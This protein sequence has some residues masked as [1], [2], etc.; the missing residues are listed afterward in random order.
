MKKTL[1]RSTPV[2]NSKTSYSKRTSVSADFSQTLQESLSLSSLCC[3]ENHRCCNLP[4]KN[5]DRKSE[6]G[7]ASGVHG[8]DGFLL[9]KTQSFVTFPYTSA[10][11]MVF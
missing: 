10:D 4:R 9:R 11:R 6:L 8:K 2:Y 5:L 1:R 7:S 3:K